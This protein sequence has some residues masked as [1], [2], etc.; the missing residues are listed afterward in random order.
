MAGRMPH[1]GSH[2][3]VISLPQR[4]ET[5]YLLFVSQLLKHCWRRLPRNHDFLTPTEEQSS[6][7]IICVPSVLESLRR[8]V[9]GMPGLGGQIPFIGLPQRR[10]SMYLLCVSQLLKQLLEATAERS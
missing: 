6:V 9:N 2:N 3:L 4:K 10:E 7:S 8:M 5:K 1:A